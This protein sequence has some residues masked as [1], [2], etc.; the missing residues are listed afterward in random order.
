[1]DKMYDFAGW[2]TRNNVRCADGRTIMQ[3]AFK[4]NDGQ[5]VP[6]FDCCSSLPY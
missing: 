1:M 4:E 6:C 5:K 2:A 3:N